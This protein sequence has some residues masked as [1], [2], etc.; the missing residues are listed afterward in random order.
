MK[1][2]QISLVGCLAFLIPKK[3]IILFP[4]IQI[5]SFIHT[6]KLIFQ[7]FHTLRHN[8][9]MRFKDSDTIEFAPESFS[10]C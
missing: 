2:S 9:E 8:I 1:T 7:R 5:T 3:M 4:H 10:M 6:T